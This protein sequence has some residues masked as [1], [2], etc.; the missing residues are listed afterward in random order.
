MVRIAGINIPDNK[1][2]EVALTYVYGIGLS[3]SQKILTELSISPDTRTKDLSPE[4][5]NKLRVEMI[6]KV[7]ETDEGMMMKYL[8][9]GTFTIEEIKAS[10]RAQRTTKSIHLDMQL[11]DGVYFLQRNCIPFGCIQK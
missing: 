11:L 1:R 9:G 8:D 7:A 6:E 3:T 10:S 4:E 5:A 2:I